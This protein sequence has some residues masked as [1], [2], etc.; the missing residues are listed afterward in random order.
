MDLHEAR[1]PRPCLYCR[2]PTLDVFAFGR[3]DFPLCSDCRFE[4]LEVEPGVG[5]R[6]EAWDTAT[7]F[8]NG[9]E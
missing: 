8:G 2:T 9:R 1:T 4:M 6:G 7:Q 5:G 3:Q